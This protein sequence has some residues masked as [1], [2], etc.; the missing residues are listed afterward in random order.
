MV[1]TLT[2]AQRSK[3]MALV[4]DRDTQPE[5]VVRRVV[6][7]NGYRY[8]LHVRTL[9]GCPDLVLPRHRKIIF[10]HGCFWHQHNCKRGSRTPKSNTDY[11]KGKL[12]RN[13]KRDAKHR[14]AL[15]QLGWD[16]L[17]IWECETTD[18]RLEKLER[19]LLSFL[20]EER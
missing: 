2:P 6:H 10:V 1:D 5:L 20:S 14:R 7:R 19:K 13:R 12:E 17:T 8:R 11:W 16:V 3:Q 18:S 4:R 9:P 15:R